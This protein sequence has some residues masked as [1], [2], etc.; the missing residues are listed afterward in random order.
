MRLG[1]IIRQYRKKNELSMGDFA[2]M[3]NLSKPY[4]SMLEANKN[5]NNGKSI[6]PSVETLRKVSST[7]GIPLDELLRMLGDEEID[8]RQVTF[9]EE[10]TKLIDCYRTLDTETK[11]L[12]FSLI[13]R[14]CESKSFELNQGFV[15][16]NSNNGN[17]Y[18]AIGGNF[19]SNITI[20]EL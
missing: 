16:H 17:N 14:L 15:I 3:T 19:N 5:S 10:E 8:L 20:K 11:N 12:V 18:G 9:N 6:A 4:I 7:I 2:K 13:N 1:E